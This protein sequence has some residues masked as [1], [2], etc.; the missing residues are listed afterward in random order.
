MNLE[1]P[2]QGLSEPSSSSELSRK[3]NEKLKNAQK[4]VRYEMVD[5]VVK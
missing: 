4:Y 3:R 1:K 5:E 2:L